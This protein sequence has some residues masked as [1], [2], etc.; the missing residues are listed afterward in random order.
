MR[1]SA[2]KSEIR[3]PNIEIRD[4]RAC[5][6]GWSLRQ[7]RSGKFKIQIP[8]GLNGC[9]GMR[10]RVLGFVERVGNGRYFF[11]E[12]SAGL[13]SFLAFCETIFKRGLG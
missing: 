4:R 1:R 10:M 5:E 3:N 8:K 11:C 9:G 13:G 7:Q 2:N 12:L 6:T